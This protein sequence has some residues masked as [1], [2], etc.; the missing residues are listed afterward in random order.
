M[1]G[2]YDTQLREY[3][4]YAHVQFGLNMYM[5]WMFGENKIS[6]FR[7]K[8][9]ENHGNFFLQLLMIR[10]KLFSSQTAKPRKILIQ[11]INI[12]GCH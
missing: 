1:Q 6:T 8:M 2:N 4:S 11:W 9:D 5:N 3:T 7:P 12:Q 10:H